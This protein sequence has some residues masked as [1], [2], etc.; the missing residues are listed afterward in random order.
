MSETHGPEHQPQAQ[1]DDSTETKNKPP[2]IDE[3]LDINNEPGFFERVKNNTR[4][5][6]GSVKT[7]A[8]IGTVERLQ[9]WWNEGKYRR[10][11]Q[12]ADQLA[13]GY[14]SSNREA[15][16]LEDRIRRQDMADA[17]MEHRFG[18]NLERSKKL[19]KDRETLMHRLE[20]VKNEREIARLKLESANYKKQAYEKRVKDIAHGV[21]ESVNERLVPQETRLA[22]MTARKQQLDYEIST[23]RTNIDETINTL[24]HIRRS[25]RTNAESVEFDFDKDAL[26]EQIREIE[27]QL[28][29]F[30]K[31]LNQRVKESERLEGS[32]KSITGKVNSWRS[33]RTQ[34]E[35][36][37]ERQGQ[38]THPNEDAEKMADVRA[39]LDAM[40]KEDRERQ[41]TPDK[42]DPEEMLALWNKVM[43]SKLRITQKQYNVFVDTRLKEQGINYLTFKHIVGEITAKK[44]SERD[45]NVFENEV[46]KA[47][48]VKRYSAKAKIVQ[49]EGKEPEA[50]G[51][52]AA[53]EHPVAEATD[54]VIEESA[55]ET[56][57]S[58]E[59]PAEAGEAIAEDATIEP[60]ESEEAETYETRE[61]KTRKFNYQGFEIKQLVSAWNE[62]FSKEYVLDAKTFTDD[63]ESMFPDR[64]NKKLLT[65]RDFRTIVENQFA[66][67]STDALG[68]K[69][70][71]VAAFKKG[72]EKFK[73]SFIENQIGNLKDHVAEDSAEFYDNEAEI[74]SFCDFWN[75]LSDDADD[76]T[77]E[78][79]KDAE[80]NILEEGKTTLGTGD[81]L[82]AVESYKKKT[83]PSFDKKG[84]KKT[85]GWFSRFLIRRWGL[86]KQK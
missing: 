71:E 5:F 26:A 52:L 33:K 70:E 60:D 40:S 43:G 28:R 57:T 50:K 38:Y 72:L 77:P 6:V 47:L 63:A 22:V 64:K 65:L 41:K 4:E 14:E 82:E 18:S 46:Q 35:K 27:L 73:A 54:V 39:R 76:I 75:D 59:G 44:I 23:F 3:N 53:G 1:P 45:W 15:H 79:L 85:V 86:K 83:L 8:R 13:S 37:F 9:T 11:G 31:N 36:I 66:H 49:E 20:Q 48:I 42:L 2:E 55:E 69:P 19:Q 16:A 25:I 80:P 58:P 29:D 21:V 10:A 7:T 32:I 67:L 24:E 62:R 68:A 84:Q 30:Q 74:A 61:V 34:Y 12:K 17:D 78:K 51:E 56:P 81:F